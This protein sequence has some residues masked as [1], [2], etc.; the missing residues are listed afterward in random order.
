MPK[1]V[2]QFALNNTRELAPVGKKEQFRGILSPHIVISNILYPCFLYCMDPDTC[3]LLPEFTDEIRELFK[4]MITHL[5]FYTLDKP[6]VLR[7]IELVTAI[8]VD[9]MTT[10][11]IWTSDQVTYTGLL[12][13]A[14][15]TLTHPNYKYTVEDIILIYGVVIYNMP[16]Y[17]D[18]GSASYRTSANIHPQEYRQHTLNTHNTK[19]NNTALHGTI[20]NLPNNSHSGPKT[21]NTWLEPVMSKKQRKYL[22]KESRRTKR[23]LNIQPVKSDLSSRDTLIK[24]ASDILIKQGGNTYPYLTNTV[25]TKPKTHIPHLFQMVTRFEV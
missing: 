1:S 5:P 2:R 19:N 11:I 16:T 23:Q 10:S 13:T 7:F 6:S 17:L 4:Y 21:N 3:D 14:F 25:K 15:N 9:T 20:W 12:T 18:L 24:L 22:V 8:L